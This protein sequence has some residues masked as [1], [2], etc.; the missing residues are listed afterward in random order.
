MTNKNWSTFLPIS[1]LIA[2]V[3][4]IFLLGRIGSNND[5]KVI[6]EGERAIATTLEPNKRMIQVSYSI[7]DKEY[8]TGVG[9]PFSYLQPLEKYEMKYMAN[10]PNSIVVFFEKPIVN[11]DFDYLETKCT[12]LN[13]S[14]SVLNFE[15]LVAGKVFKRETLFDGH[16]LNKEEY[17]IKYRK[18]NP[19][20][21]YLMKK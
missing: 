9:K 15:Y 4:G 16:S 12:S 2:I 8:T 5:E 7:D 1:I 10:D 21:G 14:F 17:V 13:R 11:G 6:K 19:K 20:I 3:L 18:N